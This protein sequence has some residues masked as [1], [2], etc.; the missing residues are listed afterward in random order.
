MPAVHTFDS[1]REAYGASQC[2]DDI[3]DGDVL[4]VPSEH[5]VG[6]LVSAWPCAVGTHHGEFH[7][8][9]EGLDWS[10]LPVDGPD[11]ASDYSESSGLALREL[12]KLSVSTA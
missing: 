6:I 8:L 4:V 12:L 2:R 10:A 5:V 1:T 11:Q 3:S 9:T 7:E